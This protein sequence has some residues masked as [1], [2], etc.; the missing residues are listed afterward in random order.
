MSRLTEY[1][2]GKPCMIRVP[3]FCSWDPATVVACHVP[4]MGYHGTSLKM[5]DFFCAFGCSICHDIVDRRIHQNQLD[6][7]YVRAL[8]L[9]GMIRTQAYILEHAPDLLARTL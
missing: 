7:S 4:L 8:H 5:H 3:G 6:P 1:A 9:E 2:E